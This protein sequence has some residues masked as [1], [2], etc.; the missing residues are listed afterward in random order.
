MP[1]CIGI[2]NLNLSHFS[3]PPSVFFQ[4]RNPKKPIGA[5]EEHDAG[6]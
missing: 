5:G 2:R 3:R 1:I 4:R 6:R